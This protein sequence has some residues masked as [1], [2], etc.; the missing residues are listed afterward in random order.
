MFKKAVIK[1]TLLYSFLFFSLFWSFSF[2][3]Y[4]Y[5]KNSFKEG[6]VTQVNERVHHEINAEGAV[7]SSE[8]FF[9]RHSSAVLDKSTELTL[10]NFRKGLILVN[11][12][13][14][15]CI[16]PL[17]WVLV[18]KTLSPV[19]DIIEKQKQFISDASHE[20]RTPLTVATNEIEITLQKERPPAYY[21]RTLNAL[22]EDISQLS[23]LA[24]NLLLLA[25][26]ED[27]SQPV[28]MQK[29]EIVDVLTKIL[30]EYS[31]RF[32]EKKVR[33]Q[34]DFPEEN[35]M[36][37]GNATMLER[38]FTNLIDNALKFSPEATT[39]TVSI[40]KKRQHVEVSIRDEGVGIA[41]EHLSKIFDRF[42]RVDASRTQTKGYGLGLAIV[43]S[44]VTLHGG[45]IALRSTPGEGSIFTVS[46][47]A[48]L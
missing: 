17:A 4:A 12:F 29:V 13:F 2:G 38:A 6:Y 42:Y 43:K 18:M 5:L 30:A 28:K 8:Q 11:T 35:S 25:R 36:V 33:Y 32:E 7:E 46:L 26:H 37:K 24:T 23:E 3:L 47:P 27:S 20:L 15:V 45:T 9:I 1:L 14:F 31:K 39:V 44:I 34:M 41:K 40:E 21:V 48:S 22:K 10:E 16:P 19:Y